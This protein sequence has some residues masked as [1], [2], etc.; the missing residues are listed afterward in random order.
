MALAVAVA[1]TI[2]VWILLLQPWST[3]NRHSP[4][5]VPT[6]G[7]SKLL[8]AVT[9]GASKQGPCSVVLLY[10]RPGMAK[11]YSWMAMPL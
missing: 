11:S 5:V 1:A 9:V 7:T 6:V 2:L 4:R 8:I 10:R 3:V